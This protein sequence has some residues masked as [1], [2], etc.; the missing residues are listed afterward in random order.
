[1]LRIGRRGDTPPQNGI[2]IDPPGIYTDTFEN[3]ADLFSRYLYGYLG[4]RLKIL[5]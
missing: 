2:C 4:F 5:L 1:M 3:K